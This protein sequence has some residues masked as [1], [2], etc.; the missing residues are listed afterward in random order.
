MGAGERW[1][2]AFPCLTRFSASSVLV[3]ISGMQSVPA[4]LPHRKRFKGP[5]GSHEGYHN[6]V[7]RK[8]RGLSQQG[9]LAGSHVGYHN[10]VSRRPR[11]LS[12]QGQLAG[13]H[14]GYHNR[15]SRKLRGLSQQ[16][17][18]A[19]SHVGYRNSVNQQE[20]VRV[21]TIGFVS[22]KP[23]GLSQEGYQEATR[24]ITTVLVSRKPR[25]LSQQDQFAGSRERYHNRFTQYGTTRVIKTR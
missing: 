14:T 19:G 9:Q 24:V 18:L 1:G 3:G 6:T 20:A 5:T 15:V 23:Q 25:G 11:G 4:V 13:S 17:Q 22:R 12:Q 10:R 2:Y 16:C 21:V 8:P 7:S